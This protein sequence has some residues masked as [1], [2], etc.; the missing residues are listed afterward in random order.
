MS[1]PPSRRRG[2]RR[3]GSGDAGISG[4]VSQILPDGQRRASGLAAGWPSMR[5]RGESV[6][7]ESVLRDQRAARCPRCSPCD[8]P[9]ETC[10]RRDRRSTTTG[11]VRSRPSSTGM[12]SDI[13][14]HLRQASR[15]RP[16]ASERLARTVTLLEYHA[17]AIARAGSMIWYRF[18]QCIC[19]ILATVRHALA[20][21]RAGQHSPCGRSAPGLQPRE[22]SRR[23]LSG[24]S[25][26]AAAQ[27]RGAVDLVRVGPGLVHSLGRRVSDSARGDRRLGHEGDAA[28]G[29][30][31]AGS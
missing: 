29:S 27:L 24:D 16:A 26:A 14:E 21:D 20:G 13:H 1:L 30:R 7:F 10:R 3:S 23:F 25:A 31:P 11:I 12:A 18:V 2:H 8:R 15:C 9:D 5:P 6:S 17:A 22:F 4:R 19:A 28:S